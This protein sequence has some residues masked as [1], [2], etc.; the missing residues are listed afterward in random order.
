[1]NYTQRLRTAQFAL[2][3]LVALSTPIP[4]FAAIVETFPTP[5]AASRPSLAEC[6]SFGSRG[7]EMEAL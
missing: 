3:W 5:T 6:G 4:A 7:L 1:M 2:L